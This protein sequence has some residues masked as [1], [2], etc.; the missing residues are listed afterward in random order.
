MPVAKEAFTGFYSQAMRNLLPCLSGQETKLFVAVATYTD[1]KGMCYPGVRELSDVTTFPEKAVSDLLADL[2]NKGLVLTVRKSERDPFTG[3]MM[4]DVYIV[5]PEILLVSDPALWLANRLRNV[6]IPES[7]FPVKSVQADRITE[8]ESGE[9]ESAKQNHSPE[10]GAVLPP[11]NAN[12]NTAM[13]TRSLQAALQY[14]G[15]QSTQTGGNRPNSAPQDRIPPSSGAPPL[16]RPLTWNESMAV[17]AI[18][19]QVPDMSHDTAADLI[20]RFGEEQFTAAVMSY[21]DRAKKVTI[22]KPT[23]WIIQNLKMGEKRR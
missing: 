4:P 17:N 11:A 18:K 22:K 19:R 5:N 2:E 15:T 10:G 1:D 13:A 16:T 8:A 12:A 7:T 23:G 20:V 6:S 14:G 3:R 21:I 9:L